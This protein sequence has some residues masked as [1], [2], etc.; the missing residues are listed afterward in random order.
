[1]NILFY[2]R[3]RSIGLLT[4]LDYFLWGYV[5]AHVYTDK[6]ASIDALQDNIEAF[7]REIPA[8]MLVRVCQNWTKRKDLLKRSRCQHWH[9][10]I[11]KQLTVWTVLSIQLRFHAFF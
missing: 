7:V 1:M 2:V 4:P 8:E 10:I 11:F 6:P 9:E 5:K 3:D